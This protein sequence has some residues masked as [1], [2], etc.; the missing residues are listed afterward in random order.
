MPSWDDIFITLNNVTLEIKKRFTDVSG[1]S[2]PILPVL[3]NH[4]AYP[5]DYYPNCPTSFF[6]DYLTRGG[7]SSVLTSAQQEQ[8]RNGGFYSHT[9]ENGNLVIVLN[10]NLYYAPNKLGTND[11]DPCGQFDWLEALL[12]AARADDIKVRESPFETWIL[13]VRKIFMASFLHPNFS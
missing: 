4:D 10:T 12:K 11:T 3:G 7:W 9:L 5:K 8:F 2:V 13:S 6:E 1:V